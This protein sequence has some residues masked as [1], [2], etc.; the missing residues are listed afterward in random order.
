MQ[1]V[2]VVR[3]D[4]LASFTMD[5]GSEKEHGNSPPLNFVGGDPDTGRFFETV[6]SLRD[7]ANERR[8]QGF[9]DDP[10]DNPET[11]TPEQWLDAYYEDREHKYNRGKKQ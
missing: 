1:E 2:W 6:G 3:S 7:L 10:Y 8:L 11:G 5:I 9:D 4:S